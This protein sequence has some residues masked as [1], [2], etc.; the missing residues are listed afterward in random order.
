MQKPFG[1]ATCVMGLLT[2]C[3][4][5]LIFQ[6]CS[7]SSEPTPPGGS[8][9]VCIPLDKTLAEA[10]ADAQAGDTLE[11]KSGS[12][13]FTES[14]TI[15]SEQTPLVIRGSRN[16]GSI[17][18]SNSVP[19]FIFESPKPG[20]VVSDLTF[21]GGNPTIQINGSGAIT[22]SGC[23]FNGG[24]VNVLANGSGDPLEVEATGNLMVEPALF[25]YQLGGNSEVTVSNSTVYGAGDC[26]VLIN[27]TAVV[28]ANNNI[29]MF[30]RNFGFACRA[31]GALR[32]ISSCNDVFMNIN[33]DYSLCGDI[34]ETDFSLDPMFC[35]AEN[36]DFTL[37]VLSPCAPEN[38]PDCG[39]VGA[40]GVGC[41]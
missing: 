2:V 30:S 37:D 34:P 6:S 9:V 12:F 19:L 41:L 27:G 10:L 21:S 39:G 25:G 28:V 22:I 23:R 17:S 36:G 26:G 5:P 29:V 4:V 32:A 40:F 7:S 33:A 11:I 1:L 24:I 14:V 13:S 31:N 20:T 16:Q 3:L 18:G 38:N 15:R 35:D 8:E